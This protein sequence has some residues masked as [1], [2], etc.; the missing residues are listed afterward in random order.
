MENQCTREVQILVDRDVMSSR[1][2][3]NFHLNQ[4]VFGRCIDSKS[5][6]FNQFC[7]YPPT[8]QLFDMCKNPNVYDVQFLFSRMLDFQL[9]NVGDLPNVI[10]YV[11]FA[12]SGDW[13]PQPQIIP[14]IDPNVVLNEFLTAHTEWFI[15]TTTVPLSSVLPLD[16]P[17]VRSQHSLMQLIKRD[18]TFII[19]FVNLPEMLVADQTKRVVRLYDSGNL[20]VFASFEDA[21]QN[22]SMWESATTDQYG[23]DVLFNTLE[24]PL[25]SI[26]QG[27]LGT[28]Q[29]PNGAYLLVITQDTVSLKY[30]AF[31]NAR[32]TASTAKI[33]NIQDA[34]DAQSKFCFQAMN[35]NKNTKSRSDL[36]FVDFR[37]NCITSD[38]L[39]SRV[40]DEETFEQLNLVTQLQ[41]KTTT[42]CLLRK[43]QL[44]PG[45]F[46]NANLHLKNV[47]VSANGFCQSL[48]PSNDNNKTIF[49]AQNCLV[50][51][52][53]CVTS[54]TC[55][56]GSSCRNRQCTLN[57]TS[58]IGCMRADPLASC[59]NGQCQVSN[60]NTATDRAG[61]WMWIG[62]GLC[63]VVVVILLVL[64]L[65]FGLR[66]T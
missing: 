2:T 37:C 23:S 15:G 50:D 10:R 54:A 13:A 60:P 29:S 58:D 32:F 65:Y 8:E 27:T 1:T 33:G 55:P 30:Q 52:S 4:D 43:C 22:I 36:E 11:R 31:N 20:R 41:L 25:T 48:F 6:Y 59:V 63:V 19:E 46:T 51:L 26:A 45:E 47:C 3:P 16:T 12:G 28:V 62:V 7:L 14:V 57:C 38:R 61:M 56:L 5:D 35:R 24:Y 21:Q 17:L 49:V 64:I 42:P 39:V 66:K 44:P 18:E 40:F 34:V 9:T 53:P